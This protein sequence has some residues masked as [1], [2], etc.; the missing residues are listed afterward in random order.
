MTWRP[1]ATP[2]GDIILYRLY[3]ELFESSAVITDSIDLPIG[4]R[5]QVGA[6]FIDMYVECTGTLTYRM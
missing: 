6:T 2:V 4:T 5:V 1:P 3:A